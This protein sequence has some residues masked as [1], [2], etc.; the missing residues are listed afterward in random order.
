MNN[1]QSLYNFPARRA[2]RLR[3]KAKDIDKRANVNLSEWFDAPKLAPLCPAGKQ[4]FAFIPF[5][6]P[7]GKALAPVPGTEEI[8][9]DINSPLKSLAF[10]Q[11]AY[12]P[13]EKRKD[14]KK[15]SLKYLTGV[16]LG[17]VRVE[18][19]DGPSEIIPLLMGINTNE[20]TPFPSSRFMYGVRYTYDTETK[21]GQKAA[22]YLLEWTNPWHFRK[23]KR[24]VWKGYGLEASPVLF[25]ISI[26][27]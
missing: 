12:L 7:E 25:G 20:F 8:A 14:F 5:I 27:L 4:T 22:L 18:Y 13:K 24:V 21:N 9:I 10:L 16:P 11:G 2:E 23:V 17:E 3:W 19:E 1:L 6:I 15:R 26:G